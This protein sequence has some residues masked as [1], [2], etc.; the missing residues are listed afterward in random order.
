MKRDQK[1]KT[2]RGKRKEKKKEKSWQNRVK[3][4]LS[5]IP[6]VCS[7][8]IMTGALDS[9]DIK[10]V[11]AGWTKNNYFQRISDKNENLL[12]QKFYKFQLHF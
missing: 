5:L 4:K 3:G 9:E 12:K 1:I 2:K 6:F 10:Y 7:L 11:E 8:N